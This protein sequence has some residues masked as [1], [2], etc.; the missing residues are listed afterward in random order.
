MN[1][2]FTSRHRWCRDLTLALALVAVFL[3]PACEDTV[4]NQPGVIRSRIVV[5]VEPNPVIGLQDEFSGSVSA[6]YLVR[7]SELEGLGGTVQ[8]L[9]STVFDP[10]IGRQVTVTV[11]DSADLIVFVGADRVDA[12]GTLE[13]TQTANYTLRGED[14]LPDGRVE[15]DLVVTVQFVDDNGNLVTESILVPIVPPPPE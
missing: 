3:L 4:S 10:M 11:W 1:D 13:V 6:A 15:A 7:I 12:N 14:G 2:R 5:F 9:T 8:F